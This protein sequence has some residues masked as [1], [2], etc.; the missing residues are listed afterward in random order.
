MGDFYDEK[1]KENKKFLP[2]EKSSNYTCSSFPPIEAGR[3]ISGLAAL[4]GT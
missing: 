2:P 3:L 4:L 1:E